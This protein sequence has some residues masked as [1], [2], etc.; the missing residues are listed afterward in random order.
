MSLPLAGLFIMV[1]CD[2]SLTSCQ[3]ANIP[4]DLRKVF[5]SPDSLVQTLL[6]HEEH[7][8]KLEGRNLSDIDV[9]SFGR[10]NGGLRI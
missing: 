9:D 5:A 8:S 1:P 2:L 6:D 3:E 4:L 10:G 7:I